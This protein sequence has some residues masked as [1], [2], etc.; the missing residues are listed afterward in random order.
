MDVPP[1]PL[2]GTGWANALARGLRV[3]RWVWRPAR[4]RERKQ[5]R[6][7]DFPLLEAA[8]DIDNNG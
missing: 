5:R 4:G 8:H 6:S 1:H 3:I 7:V 2:R